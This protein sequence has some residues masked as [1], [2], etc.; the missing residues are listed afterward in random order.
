MSIVPVLLS[1]KSNPSKVIKVY[2]LLDENSQGVFIQQEVLHSLKSPTRPT[3]IT[4]ETLNGLFTDAALAVDGLQVR[5]LPSFESH[6]GSTVIEL[7]TA[8][9]REMLSLHKDEVPTAEKY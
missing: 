6:Y 8:Y 3:H 4:T 1:H 7:P 2:A 9:S 5:P